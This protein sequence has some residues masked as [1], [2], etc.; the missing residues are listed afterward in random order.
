MDADHRRVAGRITTDSVTGTATCQRAGDRNA[1]WRATG[2]FGRA[3]VRLL[4]RRASPDRDLPGSTP[5]TL[6][7][8]GVENMEKD[9]VCGMQVNP[10]Q[11]AAQRS[12][13]GKTYYFCSPGCATK[14]DREPRRYVAP[15][16]PKGKSSGSR[17]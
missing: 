6:Q 13:Q 4:A 9:P 2:K 7:S 11:A 10:N 17:H 14:F 5:P 3:P 12:H 16:S 1:R 8:K 15:D